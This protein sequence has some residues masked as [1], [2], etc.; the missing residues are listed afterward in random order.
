MFLTTIIFS[1]RIKAT[2][3]RSVSSNAEYELEK[4]QDASSYMTLST[5]QAAENAADYVV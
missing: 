1:D 2:A 5:M 4:R 3:T